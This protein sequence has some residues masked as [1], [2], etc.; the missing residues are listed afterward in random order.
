ML[1]GHF[2]MARLHVRD[3][4][5]LEQKWLT[6]MLSIL[7]TRYEIDPIYINWTGLG[8]AK[9]PQT[10]ITIILKLLVERVVL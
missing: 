10:Y 9:R 5:E 6:G 2:V 1:S 3:L 7:C 4:M 8:Q